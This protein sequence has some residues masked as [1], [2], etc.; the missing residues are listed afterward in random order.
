[1]TQFTNTVAVNLK[2]ELWDWFGAKLIA[3]TQTMLIFQCLETAT[4][5]LLIELLGNNSANKLRKSTLSIHYSYYYF[6][7]VTMH[8]LN[9]TYFRNGRN[10]N[11]VKCCSAFEACLISKSVQA[12]SLNKPP[13]YRGMLFCGTPWTSGRLRI[14]TRWRSLVQAV[15]WL[16]APSL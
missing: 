6:Y 7:I 2:I 8:L 9:V 12:W 16:A 15:G 4:H 10:I 5:L 14:K 1:M 13:G 3:D 11:N